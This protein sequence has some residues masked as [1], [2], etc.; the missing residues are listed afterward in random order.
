MALHDSS[1]SAI[2]SHYRAL[3]EKN[4]TLKSELIRVAIVEDQAGLRESLMECLS[5]S[6][7]VQCI[8]ALATAEEAIAQ[9]PQW[10]LDVVFMDIN[11]PGKSGVD[12][13]GAL[14]PL[15]PNTQFVML[16]AYDHADA[17]FQSLQ[18]G[19]NGYLQKPVK[20]SHLENAAK[21]IVA[22]GSPMS[23]KIARMVV[24]A[25]YKPMPKTVVE[26]PDY[27]LTSREQSVLDAL[28]AGQLYKEI[29]DQLNVSEHTVHFHIRNVYKKL[30]VR[31]RSQAI[32]KVL[33]K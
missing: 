32:A 21:E 13:V 9:L 12:A 17:V 14:A 28:V 11:L 1:D 10:D 24:Q 7:A 26:T 30:Q 25:F 19:A 6:R 18:A 16:T 5:S 31:S 2:V 3:A 23:G 22:G 15:M 33:Q 20:T 4:M 29:A 27:Q 8:G